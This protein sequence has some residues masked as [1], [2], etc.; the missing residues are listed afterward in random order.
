MQVTMTI[1]AASIIARDNDRKSFKRADLQSLADSIAEHGLVNPPVVT[2]QS[3]GTYLITGGERRVRAM[4][5]VLQWTE[6]PV[7]VDDNIN[8]ELTRLAKMWAENTF[9]KDL[10]PMEEATAIARMMTLSGKTV[11]DTARD[12]CI[13]VDMADRRL[14]LLTLAESVQELIRSG[15]LGVGHAEQMRGL[16]RNFQNLAL[17]ALNTKR[18]TI[19]DFGR[20]CAELLQKQ[21]A[22]SMFDMSTFMVGELVDSLVPDAIKPVKGQ[23]PID[24]TLPVPSEVFNGIRAAQKAAGGKQGLTVASAIEYYISQ[25]LDAGDTESV[26]AAAAIGT[27]YNG[28]IGCNILKPPTTPILA[29]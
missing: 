6:I 16:D 10:N 14:G 27:I 13:T 26:K 19:A 9:R 4:R 21:M 17:D 22:T 25:L 28:L 12:M 29:R 18:M 2:Y 23:I 5:D 15:Q 24:S 3:D 8:D 7:I 1:P 11:Q 20:I